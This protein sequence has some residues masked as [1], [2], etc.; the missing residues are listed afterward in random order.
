V[1]FER[2]EAARHIVLIAHI[3]PDADSLGSA[4]AMYT[5]MLRLQ[6]KVTFF[7]ATEN[8]DTRLAF[9]PW[10][11][12]IRH[13]FPSSADLAISFDCGTKGRLGVEAAIPLINIDHHGSNTLY[14]DLN[15]VDTG[16][17]STTQVVYEL[18]FK[19]GIKPNTKMATALYAGLIDDSI[20]FRSE[21]VSENTFTLAASLVNA[22]AQTRECAKQLFERHSLAALRLKGLILQ[23]LQLFEAGR[24]AVMKVSR[25]MMLQSGAHPSDCEAPLYESMGLPTVKIALMLRQK[26]DGSIKGS[27]RCDH[28]IDVS[29]IAESFGGGGHRYAAGFEM[30]D[31]EINAAADAVLRKIQKELE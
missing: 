6:K 22:G 20:S 10:F 30:A 21:R 1:L 8:I 31:I 15:I 18:L 4:S 27:L 5:Q 19:H 14:G 23:E 12:K 26:Q 17:V 24:I 29:K 3:N 2:I 28:S 13:Q 16:A 11:D 25:E 9:L 7:C